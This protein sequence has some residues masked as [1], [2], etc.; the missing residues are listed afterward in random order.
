MKALTRSL[1]WGAL[2]LGFAASPAAAA[3]V[4]DASCP[5]PADS[6]VQAGGTTRFAQSFTAKGSGPLVRADLDVYKEDHPGDATGDYLF[7]INATDS[8]GVPTDQVLASATV[9]DASVVP[10]H[11]IVTAR[12]PDP[13]NVSA[14]ESYALVLSRPTANAVGAG[15]RD[16]APCSGHAWN[17]FDNGPFEGMGPPPPPVTY[18]DLV[19]QVF[20]QDSVPPKTT[21]TRKP[22]SEISKPTAKFKFRSDEADS[23]FE[24][25]L[26]GKGLKTKVK[27]FGPCASP[28]RYKHLDPGTYRFAVQATDS[29]G[30]V[31]P[32]PAKAKFKV[33]G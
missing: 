23:T 24:C 3:D 33:V 32:T 30:N 8:S 12:F 26:K 21:I 6:M 11:S 9:D 5:G 18:F 14:G 16:A 17:S 29:S 15:F 20:L 22:D 4:P 13:V 7:S 28:K 19:Y 27:H 25:R 31:D 2:L 1:V 10:G